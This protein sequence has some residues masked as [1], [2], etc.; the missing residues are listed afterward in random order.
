MLP[1]PNNKSMYDEI[2]RVKLVSISD[3]PRNCSPK[4]SRPSTVIWTSPTCML[5][6]FVECHDSGV[7][8]CEL[9]TGVSSVSGVVACVCGT[10]SGL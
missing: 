9:H 1:G 3:R 6:S 4:S 2:P 5:E 8:C 10:M 7:E